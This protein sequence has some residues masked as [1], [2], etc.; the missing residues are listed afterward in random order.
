MTPRPSLRPNPR[1]NPRRSALYLP[2]SNA[3]AIAKARTSACDVVILDLEDAV[4]PEMKATA[5]WQAIDA[6]G[7]FGEREV[8]I[9][10]NGIDTDWGKDDLAALRDLPIDGVLLPKVS[11][12]A[13]LVEARKALSENG[14]PLWAMIETCRAIV[15]L[16]AIVTAGRETGLSVLVAGT[17]DLAKEMRCR[18]GP[19]RTPLLP[20]LS[21]IVTCAR[22]AGIVALDG[23]CNTIDDEAVVEAECEQALDW[24]F[25]GKTLIHPAQ[26]AA[27]NRVFTPAHAEVARARAIVAAFDDPGNAARG[28]IRVDGQMVELLHLDDARRVLAFAERCAA[29]ATC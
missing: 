1:T 13:T 25:D 3:R 10:V 23:V 15:D 11:D 22:M 28:A 19:A 17:N 20:A 29:S 24:G 14:P 5:R 9:R 21:H 26:I 6:A 16:R 18:P 8:V 12:P 27:A 4:A 2:A 7:S